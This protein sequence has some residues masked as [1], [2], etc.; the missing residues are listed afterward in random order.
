M[1]LVFCKSS[2]LRGFGSLFRLL[3]KL[4]RPP[5][6]PTPN[7]ESREVSDVENDKDEETICPSTD[8]I[9]GELENSFN[10][11]MCDEDSDGED[12]VNIVV[13]ELEETIGE[14]DEQARKILRKVSCSTRKGIT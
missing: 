7:V 3:V 13:K 12:F 4:L 1:S 11:T 2:H 10:V 14:N 6:L 9:N 8:V 5:S